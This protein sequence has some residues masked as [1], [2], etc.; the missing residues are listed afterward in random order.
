LALTPDGEQFLPTA[1]RLLSD[2]AFAIE[3]LHALADRRRGRVG[4]AAVYSIATSVLP[5]TVGAFASN[6]PSISVHLRDDNSA[7]VCRRVRRAEVDLGFAS[8]DDK[9]PELDYVHLL[10]DR[11][12]IVAREDH[13]LMTRRKALSWTDLRD[14]EFLGLASDTGPWLAVANADG[15]PENIK[16]PR[17]QL[18]NIPTLSAM[19]EANLGVT[20][21]PALAF[22]AGGARGLLRYRP[23]SNPIAMRDVYL[24]T[25]KGRSI[26]WAAQ[27]LKTMIVNEI[28]RLRGASDL[29]EVLIQ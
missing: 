8:R 27:V 7:G 21:L 6:Y 1:E 23:L 24:V 3:D 15:I 18:S 19:L 17:V 25:R 11:M 4:I 26:S 12:G 2:F 22:P 10:R 29:I 16:N 14:Y 13:P 9:D 20:A 5:G 28:A